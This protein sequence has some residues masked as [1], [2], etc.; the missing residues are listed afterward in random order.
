MMLLWVTGG[1]PY[2]IGPLESCNEDILG[3]SEK[4]SIFLTNSGIYICVVVISCIDEE[5][6]Y[7][8][9]VIGSAVVT[10]VQQCI[11]FIYKKNPSHCRCHDYIVWCEF[12]FCAHFMPR[13]PTWRGLIFEVT[14][15]CWNLAC[16]LLSSLVKKN[17]P[18][19]FFFLQAGTSETHAWMSTLLPPTR[20]KNALCSS[21]PFCTVFIFSRIQ[22]P[23]RLETE[24][25]GIGSPAGV[26]GPLNC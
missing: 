26:S 25:W 10:V 24:G 4:Q 9:I 15:I 20:E 17:A 12:V 22:I 19:V 6:C 18:V 11:L 16:G 3:F 14:Q 8:K 5:Y 7:L 2:F 21:L 13:A 1:G 23:H